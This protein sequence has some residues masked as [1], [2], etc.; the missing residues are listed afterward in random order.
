MVAFMDAS[1]VAPLRFGGFELDARAGQLTRAGRRVHLA[2]QSIRLL[3]LLVQRAGEVVTRDEIRIALW[4]DDTFVDFDAAVNACVSQIRMALGDKATAPRFVETLPRRGYRFVAPVVSTPG[5][6][7]T[8]AAVESAA[9]PAALAPQNRRTWAW[10]AAALALVVGG[11]TA[12]AFRTAPSATS[13]SDYARKRSLEA[14]QKL[15]RGASGLADASPSELL[16]RVKHFEVAIEKEPDFAEAYAGLAEAKLI[17][18]QYR[19]EAP[20]VAYPAAKAAAAKAISLNPDLG[21]AQAIYAAAVLHFEWDWDS[22]RAHFARAL[23]LAPASPRVHYWYGRYLTAKGRHAEALRHALR[24]M[25]LTPTSPSAVTGAG[26][27]EFY[28]GRLDDAA[29]HCARGLALMPEFVPAQMCLDAV[30][31]ARE[32]RNSISP[33]G[34]LA[35]AVSLASSGEHDRAL[36]WL[37]FAANRHSDALIFAAI[38]PAFDPLKR[39]PRFTNIL[40]R[41]GL[42]PSPYP[43]Q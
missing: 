2:P 33:D 20:Q 3:T 15:E 37:Q 14:I 28:A 40:E 26:V 1:D 35:T 27:A 30:K 7:Q 19:A 10:I 41:V 29:A 23:S 9:V 12:S 24:A 31:T 5:P 43:V 42:R 8:P 21:Y 22:A 18:A 16:A 11:L 32:G 36:E 17:V 25:S 38:Q 4:G 6:V 13:P 34:M 39:D